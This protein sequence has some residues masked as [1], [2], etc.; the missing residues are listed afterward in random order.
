MN[1]AEGASACTV[2]AATPNNACSVELRLDSPSGIL[3]GT[4]SIGNTG[5]W[6]TY[7]DFTATVTGATGS[8]D[9]YLVFKGGSG[10]LMNVDQF[11]FIPV[12]Q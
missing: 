4:V 9:L 3:V 11:T 12:S 1:F 8:H 2:R 6:D 7:S 10:Y 5:G